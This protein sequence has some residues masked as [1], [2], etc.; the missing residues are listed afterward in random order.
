MVA[1]VRNDRVSR[2]AQARKPPQLIGRAGGWDIQKGVFALERR[3]L[4]IIVLRLPQP[5]ELLCDGC[6]GFGD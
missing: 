3:F 6:S 2:F 1:N 4:A 5:R